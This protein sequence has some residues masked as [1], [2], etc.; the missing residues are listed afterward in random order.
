MN[1]RLSL[2]IK[3]KVQGV[4]YRH[5]VKKEA[6]RLEIKGFVR[7][8]SDGSVLIKAEGEEKRLEEFIVRC[9]KG[10]PLARIEGVEIIEEKKPE[11]FKNFDII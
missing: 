6:E 7:N 2:K 3:G 8:E 4:F 10:P 9:R 1:K 11:D 5:F